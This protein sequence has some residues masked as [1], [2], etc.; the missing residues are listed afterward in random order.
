MILPQGDERTDECASL[1]K[2]LGV[3]YKIWLGWNVN[4]EASSFNESIL[5]LVDE[6][7]SAATGA[8]YIQ[9]KKKIKTSPLIKLYYIYTRLCLSK[10]LPKHHHTPEEFLFFIIGLCRGRPG[11]DCN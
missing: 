7:T 3:R 10:G 5:T 9:P 2:T 11:Y 8:I 6:I 4:I 1:M